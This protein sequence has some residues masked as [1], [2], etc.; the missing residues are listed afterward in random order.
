[1][2]TSHRIA[3]LTIAEILILVRDNP[4]RIRSE[5]A[6]AK[7][8]GYVLFRLPAKVAFTAIMRKLILLANTLIQQGRM[9]AQK[10]LD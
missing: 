9:W 7:L 6:L 4:G 1:M 2:L 5:A 8:C 3:T 10:E